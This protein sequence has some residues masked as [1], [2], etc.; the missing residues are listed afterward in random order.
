[1][2]ATTIFCCNQYW[3][4]ATIRMTLGSKIWHFV[5]WQE[6]Y[7]KHWGLSGLYQHPINS[8]THLKFL[9]LLTPKKV[10]KFCHI[11]WVRSSKSVWLRNIPYLSLTIL[12]NTCGNGGLGICLITFIGS[13]QFICQ[14]NKNT[15]WPNNAHLYRIN[16]RIRQERWS[17]SD[18]SQ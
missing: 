2:T 3:L 18:P 14:I 17:W 13:L 8:M 15:M 16:G 9:K 12:K 7:P 4:N 11:Y 6:H 10:S 5:L 1:M